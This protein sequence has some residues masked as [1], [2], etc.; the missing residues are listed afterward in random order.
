MLVCLLRRDALDVQN[1]HDAALRRHGGAPAAH[2]GR[3]PCHVN[4]SQHFAR[5]DEGDVL[6]P[7]SMQGFANGFKWGVASRGSGEVR[8]LT[9]SAADAG[10]LPSTCS[11]SCFASSLAPTLLL[12]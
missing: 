9:L 1:W 8:A 5:L 6:W 10:V 4:I 11:Y 2:A 7:F 3:P 12:M